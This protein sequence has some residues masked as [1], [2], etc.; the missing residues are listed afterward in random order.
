MLG[1]EDGAEEG[2]CGPTGRNT[3]ISSRKL[4]SNKARLAL[5]DEELRGKATLVDQQLIRKSEILAL[6]GGLRLGLSGELGEFLGRIGDAKENVS[7][8]RSSRLCSYV[9]AATQKAIEELHRAE[10]ELDDVT[11]QIRAAQDVVERT[12]VRSPVRG[13]VVKLESVYG[14]WSYRP[15][16]QHSRAAAVKRR[17]HHR[18]AGESKRDNACETRSACSC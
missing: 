12:E 8:E 5:F 11:E 4:S 3:R 7:H 2:D 6:C 1:Q 13:T 16:W 18:G 14:R 17:A 9:A 15:R 10:S